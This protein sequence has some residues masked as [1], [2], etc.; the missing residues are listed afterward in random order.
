MSSGHLGA[1]KPTLPAAY[2]AQEFVSLAWPCPPWVSSILGVRPR[3]CRLLPASCSNETLT[4]PVCNRL[5]KKTNSQKP[6]RLCLQHCYLAR[7]RS[8]FAWAQTCDQQI[9]KQARLWFLRAPAQ[10]PTHSVIFFAKLHLRRHPYAALKTGLS[11]ES[12][13]NC[14]IAR[15]QHAGLEITSKCTS[16]SCACFTYRLRAP[17]CGLAC[18]HEHVWPLIPARTCKDFF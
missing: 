7:F 16:C 8:S 12:L 1:E 2:V 13:G 11:S 18:V 9:S 17:S 10:R 5:K 15:I 6:S 3:P 14:S 4:V